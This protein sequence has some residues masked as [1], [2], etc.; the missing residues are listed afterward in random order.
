MCRFEKIYNNL[1]V[2]ATNED[3]GCVG[4]GV[5]YAHDID[6]SH[7]EINGVNYSAISLGW[8][9]T[10][11][12]NSMKNNRV[13]ANKIYNFARML[14][15]VGGVYTLSAQP[16]SV[17]DS[18]SIFNLLDAPYAHIP[19]H[20]QYIYFDEGSSYIRAINNWTERDKFFSNTPGPGNEWENNGPEVSE[21]IKNRAGLE[22]NFIF[23]HKKLEK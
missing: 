7:N 9:W 6:I 4:I 11:A 13:H 16:N 21:E 12:V 23:L 20:H 3:W 22:D 5:G 10:K 8:G 15:D 2:D 17:I 19:D 14:Y 1:I 18:N